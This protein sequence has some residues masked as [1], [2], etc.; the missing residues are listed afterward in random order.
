MPTIRIA[1]FNCENLFARYRFQSG[2]P[3]KSKAGVLPPAELNQ[4]WGFLPPESW[5]QSFQVFSQ[6][7]WRKVTARALKG[8]DGYPDV[9][10]LQEVENLP[11]LRRFNQDY[12]GHHYPFLKVIDSHDPRNID[13]GVLSRFPI[14]RLRSHVDD[15]APGGAWN[16]YVFSRD[17]IEVT[18][19]VSGTPLHILVNHLKSKFARTSQEKRRA[20]ERRLAQAGAVAAIVR[21]RFGKSSWKSK[22]LVVVGDFNDQPA[23]P[24]LQPLLGMGFE[25]VVSRLPANQR[26]THY[27][28]AKSLVSQLVY[29]LLSP[30]LADRA[31]ALPQIER[32]GLVKKRNMRVFL[33]TADDR[34]GPEVPLATQRFPGVTSKIAASDHCPVVMRLKL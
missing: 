18:V 21:D 16:A 25:N 14:I 13:V 30:R 3:G 17:C 29:L 24:F 20:D 26:W 8:S 1:T 23:S 19:D 6:D 12:L 9:V 2:P 7:G 33:A 5:K 27:W 32:R 28:G 31:T 11:V 4:R 15:V 22:N 10:C 34:R